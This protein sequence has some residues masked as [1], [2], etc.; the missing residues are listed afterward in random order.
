MDCAQVNR[1]IELFVLGDLPEAEQTAV[2]NHLASCPACR[3]VED[4]YRFLVAEIRESTRPDTVKADFKFAREVRSAVQMEIRR[5][6]RRTLARRAIPVAGSVAACLLVAIAGW[7]MWAASG[8]RLQSVLAHDR[9]REIVRTRASAAPS[10]LPAWQRRSDPTAPGSAA[11]AVVV[12]NNSIYLL[13]TYG[14]Q[15]Y[16]AALDTRTG[17]QKWLSDI[18]SCGYLLADDSRVYCLAPGEAGKLDLVALDAANGK[19]LWR[20]QQERADRLQSPCRASLLSG[21]RICWAADRTVHMLSRIDGAPIWTHSIPDGGLLSA[22][23]AVDDDL[24]VANAFGLYCL[25]AGTGE[26]SW[27]LACGDAKSGRGRP[28]L[29]AADGVIYASMNL[30]LRSSRLFCMNAAQRKILWSRVVDCT[31]RLDAIG[32]VLYVRDQNIQAL[33]GRTGRSLWTCPAQG[34]NPV[35]YTK[36]LAYFVDSRDQG[37]LV[38][39]DRY[40]GARVWELAGVKSCDAFIRVNGRG[41]LKTPDGLVCA[42]IFKG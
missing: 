7:G 2:E 17:E 36:E 28:M 10:A 19:L 40:T 38:A 37:R 32:D 12:R 41:F 21:G 42:L 24:Y 14:Q 9:P 1:K 18:R 33:D 8:S 5:A 11:D 16:V 27:H 4:E 31:A 34:C 22:A 29:A 20:H 6:S 39:L 35:T 13:H 26:E 30:G 23:A 15:N 3:V 25:D